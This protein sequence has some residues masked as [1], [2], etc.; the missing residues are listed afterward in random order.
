MDLHLYL[1]RMFQTE[2]YFKPQIPSSINISYFSEKFHFLP[3]IQ[4]STP[5]V[6]L[7]FV[8]PLY[9]VICPT[10]DSTVTLS[11]LHIS[12]LVLIDNFSLGV[13]FL[14][15]KLNYITTGLKIS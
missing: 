3:L 8:H 4:T 7:N 6:M 10:L 9:P 12:I 14:K 13:M 5:E 11:L 2:F 1:H 15:C